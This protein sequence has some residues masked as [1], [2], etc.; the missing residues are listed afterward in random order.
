MG[1]WINLLS[2]EL[3]NELKEGKYISARSTA[4]HILD[5]SRSTPV[6]QETID[7][8]KD[9]MMGLDRKGYHPD[10]IKTLLQS[11]GQSMESYCPPGA[12]L[13]PD[14]D[15]TLRTWGV[16]GGKAQPC[17]ATGRFASWTRYAQ[18]LV[19]SIKEDTIRQAISER[20][21][22]VGDYHDELFSD[23]VP[24]VTEEDSQSYEK[25]QPFMIQKEDWKLSIPDDFQSELGDLT[26][27]SHPQE[28][29]KGDP[30][31][32]FATMVMH[33]MLRVLLCKWLDSRSNLLLLQNVLDRLRS[34]HN[35]E[36][37]ENEFEKGFV[38][39]VTELMYELYRRAWTE[40]TKEMNS[41]KNPHVLFCMQRVIHLSGAREV[42][43]AQI[44]LHLE[45]ILTGNTVGFMTVCGMMDQW[46]KHITNHTKV[47]VEYLESNLS[48][49]FKS[50]VPIWPFETEKQD[51]VYPL[52]A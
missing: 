48:K 42:L 47:M 13:H 40:V 2:I 20:L 31:W 6:N 43:K 9:L 33:R 49:T 11:S 21:G 51:H 18:A 35:Q 38:T 46:K 3:E 26:G 1:D 23:W 24:V 36:R 37:K 25:L 27:I 34:R 52:K 8:L 28:W 44:S 7:F 4:Q 14:K 15:H 10:N 5:L 29:V 30:D 32:W 39:E 41:L 16:K 22:L 50:L 12:I 19:K 45:T 17:Y